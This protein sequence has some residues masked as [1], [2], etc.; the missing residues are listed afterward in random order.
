MRA[1]SRTGASLLAVSDGYEL[2]GACG[3][4]RHR[5]AV[6]VLYLHGIQS[7]GG[8]FEWSAACVARAAGPCYWPIGAAAD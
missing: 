8:W 1:P 6:A 5:R 2:H 4:G 3:A 7:H